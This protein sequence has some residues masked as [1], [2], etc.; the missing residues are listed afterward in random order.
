MSSCN[1]DCKTFFLRKSKAIPDEVHVE[2]QANESDFISEIETLGG[3]VYVVGGAVRDLLYNLIHKTK[4]EVKDR[5]LIV[6][7]LDPDKLIVVLKKYGTVKEVGRKFGVIKFRPKQGCTKEIDIALP[8][9]EIIYDYNLSLEEDFKHRDATINA[10]AIRIYN[11]SDLESDHIDENNIID[12][13][14][15]IQDLKNRVWKTIGNPI[16]RFTEDPT[17]ILR[18]LRQCSQLNLS[19]DL[20]TEISI[21]DNYQM[22][23]EISKESAVR[24]TDELVRMIDGKY[25]YN[26]LDFIYKSGIMNF[27][28]LPNNSYNNIRKI[29]NDSEDIHIRIKIALMLDANNNKDCVLWT[30]ISDLSAAPHYS[31][32][33]V[34]FIKCVNM[35][36]KEISELADKSLSD[37]QRG[38]FMRKLLQSTEKEFPNLA[39]SYVCDLIKYF[40]IYTEY[41]SGILKKSFE[42]N[43]CIILSSSQIRLDGNTI[44]KMWPNICGKDIKRIKYYLFECVTEDKVKNNKDDLINFIEKYGIK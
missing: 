29:I 10:L 28:L 42:D 18:A 5:D 23:R 39:R 8:R 12:Y 15:G 32:N 11:F 31:K 16:D 7:C 9:K 20:Q 27:L 22:L 35:F 36:F 3:Q 41:P 24:G 43:M 34:G 25:L 21:R 6:R 37:R 1:I 14:N 17:R 2:A 38:I 19:L 26:I 44:M 33:N 30:K 4:F 40:E 13:F